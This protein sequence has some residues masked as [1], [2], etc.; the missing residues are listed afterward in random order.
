MWQNP[1][2]CKIWWKLVKDFCSY[3]EPK[4][5]LYI[6]PTFSLRHDLENQVKVTKTLYDLQFDNIQP[7][8]KFVIT[9]SQELLKLSCT[10]DRNVQFFTLFQAQR[11]WKL[12][13]GHQNLIRARVCP[14]T[15]S[16]QIWR[17]SVKC[18][19]SDREDKTNAEAVIHS[20]NC[21]SHV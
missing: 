12:C 5:K 4:S 19:L 2:P 13:Q 1:H 9:I 14:Y 3:L 8:A 18:F 7:R 15:P 17:Q 16:V 6:F 11:P 21:I 20:Q 10:Q